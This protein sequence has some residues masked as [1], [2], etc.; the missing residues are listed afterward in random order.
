M[1]LN[2][3]LAI[4]SFL[5]VMIVPFYSLYKIFKDEEKDE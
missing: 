4:T 2:A 1:D 5:I 3:K